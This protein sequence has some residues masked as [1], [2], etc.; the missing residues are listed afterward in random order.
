MTNAGMTTLDFTGTCF[1][2][3]ETL[4][5]LKSA[6]ASWTVHMFCQ[7]IVVRYIEYQCGV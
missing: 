5:V 3:G 6:T 4:V 2:A 1:N 7:N